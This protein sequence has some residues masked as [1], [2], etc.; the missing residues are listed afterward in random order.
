VISLFDIIRPLVEDEPDMVP[1]ND[2]AQFA[3]EQRQVCKLVYQIRSG[4]VDEEFKIITQMR[5]LF[6][7]GGNRRLAYTLQ[8]VF[9]AGL[10]MIEKIHNEKVNGGSPSL[11]FKKVFGFVHKTNSCLVDVQSVPELAFQNW[12]MAAL[13]SDRVADSG[14]ICK[15]FLEQAMTNYDELRAESQ[16]KALQLIVGTLVQISTVDP[17]DIDAFNTK[18]IKSANTTFFKKNQKSRA[19]AVA[20]RLFWSPH[21]QESQRVNECLTRCLKIL[22][23]AITNEPQ[24]VTAVVDML[25]DFIYYVEVG[26]ADVA[27]TKIAALIQLSKEHIGFARESGKSQEAQ[28]AEAHLQAYIKYIRSFKEG[29]AG[30]EQ[31]DVAQRFAAIDLP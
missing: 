7:K 16:F 23:D 17:S 29:P 13:A 24:L 6:G 2:E 10:A 31:P 15:E 27:A 11:T 30:R 5:N 4:S 12:L 21:R 20:S 1:V 18:V 25:E 28:Q 3:E 26:C 22:N 8:P 9:H 19:I 14:Q